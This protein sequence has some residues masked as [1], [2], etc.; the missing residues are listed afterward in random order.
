LYTFPENLV[1]RYK[2]STKKPVVPNLRHLMLKISLTSIIVELNTDV[3]DIK[4]GMLVE[5]NPDQPY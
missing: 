4:T 2:Y 1:K 3:T 5:K